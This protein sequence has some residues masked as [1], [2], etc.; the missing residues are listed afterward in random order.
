MSKTKRNIFIFFLSISLLIIISY[1]LYKSLPLL[2]SLKNSETQKKL[3]NYITAQGWKGWGILLLIQVLQ[4]FIAFLP[5]EV[6]EIVAGLLYGP[7][8]GLFICLLGI[9][10]GS[11]L[12]YY[13]IKLFAKNNLNKYKSKLQTYS[14]LNNPKKVHFYLFILFLLPGI[15]KDIFIYIAPFLPIEFTSFL[16]I[17]LFARIPSILSSTIIGNSLM[18]GNYLTSIIIFV[19]FAIIGIIAILFKEKLFYLFKKHE[20]KSTNNIEN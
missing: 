1:F 20:D 9:L 13:T 6:V 4:I 8:G 2:S 15:P 18:E 19:V 5:G 10:I 11:L 14:F 12:I 3:E 17:S 7:I 16:I